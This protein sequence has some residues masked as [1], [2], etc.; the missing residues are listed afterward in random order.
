MR[1][2]SVQPDN[3]LDIT[4]YESRATSASLAAV[5]AC[6]LGWTFD[7]ASDDQSPAAAQ[8]R[9]DY[10]MGKPPGWQGRV[11]GATGRR[12]L[13]LCLLFQLLTN[14]VEDLAGH[15]VGNRIDK[16]ATDAGQ[17]AADLGVRLPGHHRAAIFTV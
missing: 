12:R 15:P 5:G 13:T 16:A 10:R 17:P 11:R 2:S 14:A 7:L 4:L 3:Y 9:E 8:L 6:P 1:N